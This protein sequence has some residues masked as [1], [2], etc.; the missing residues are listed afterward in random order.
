MNKICAGCNEIIK[1]GISCIFV[2]DYVFHNNST[3]KTTF[4]KDVLLKE[5]YNIS[6][7]P[8]DI[9]SIIHDNITSFVERIEEY[10]GEVNPDNLDEHEINLFRTLNVLKSSPYIVLW[11]EYLEIDDE[12]HLIALEYS[13]I[14][15]MEDD[16]NAKIYNLLDCDT[17]GTSGDEFTECKP[18]F[19]SAYANGNRMKLRVGLFE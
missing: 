3:C 7:V 2:G 10:H 12:Y 19:Y 1:D 5:I 6:P 4:E 11:Q 13:C 15:E 8:N 17:T 14:E 16:I 18:I 9:I